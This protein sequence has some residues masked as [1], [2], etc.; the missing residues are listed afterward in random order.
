MGAPSR[1]Q[2]VRLDAVVACGSRRLV[3]RRRRVLSSGA[4]SRCCEMGMS[5]LDP[6]LVSA[7]SPEP[8]YC[9]R[10]ELRHTRRADW[11]CPRC[12]SPVST[13]LPPP[14]AAPAPAA[15][16]RFPLAAR[17]AGAILLLLAGALAGVA[18]PLAMSPAGAHRWRI[19]AFAAALA[20]L[21]IG[22]A[23]KVS[24]ARF[25]AAA[26]AGAA[27]LV[28]SE[29]LL[30]VVLPG[31]VRDPLPA[32]AR[33]LL[34]NLIRDHDP[35]R[36]LLLLAFDAGCLL[37]VVGQPRRRRIVVGLVLAAPLLVRALAVALG[38]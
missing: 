16:P 11:L 35:R 15:E 33:Q 1:A 30:R 6:P 18:G 29:A 23:L 17:M 20:G 13:E 25:A 7:P 9:P 31:L 5:S 32:P 2:S 14:R 22:L 8:A 26:L 24:L 19:L 37:L 3:R 12:G 21:G 34:R 27:A 38:R 10:C 36:L 28:L 4:S